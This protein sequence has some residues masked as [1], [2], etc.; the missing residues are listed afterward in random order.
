MGD[1]WDF[2]IKKLDIAWTIAQKRIESKY[3]HWSKPTDRD[4][5]MQEVE[6]LLSDVWQV[7]DNSFP[8]L[9]SE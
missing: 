5:F 7:V 9:S 6:E 2:H 1:R 4:K 3:L 8:P